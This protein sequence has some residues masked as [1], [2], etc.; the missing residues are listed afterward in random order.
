[1]EQSRAKQLKWND[2][3]NIKIPVWSLYA[4]LVLTFFNEGMSLAVGGL[5]VWLI[6]S[7]QINPAIRWNRA[8][9]KKIWFFVLSSV[10]VILLA[11]GVVFY[12]NKVLRSEV[13]QLVTNYLTLH[14]LQR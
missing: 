14:G 3:I 1:M 11:I 4:L 9:W 10:F 13:A 12:H 6:S 7:G 8:A 5:F 2:D